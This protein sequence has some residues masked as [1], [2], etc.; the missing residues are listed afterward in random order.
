MENFFQMGL[1]AEKIIKAIKRTEL[2]KTYGVT[3]FSDFTDAMKKENILF[4]YQEMMR[5][6]KTRAE[7]IYNSELKEKIN[8]FEI[9]RNQ[10]LEI[11]SAK[12]DIEK[13]LNDK[14]TK[15][16]II[17]QEKK[18]LLEKVLV[19]AKD[20]I[21]LNDLVKKIKLILNELN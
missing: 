5:E 1:P 9:E 14:K 21:L 8:N 13:F 15:D 12:V 18:E 20:C 7:R 16:E 17:T 3:K 19:F 4:T 10:L 11:E 2:N 6:A